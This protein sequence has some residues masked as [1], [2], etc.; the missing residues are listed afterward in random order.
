MGLEGQGL[1][2]KKKNIRWYDLLPLGSLIVCIDVHDP[3]RKI[4][5]SNGDNG[6]N[7]LPLHEPSKL[8][9]LLPFM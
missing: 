2:K 6:V 5:S 3:F 4:V 9:H 7:A 8:I 1:Y